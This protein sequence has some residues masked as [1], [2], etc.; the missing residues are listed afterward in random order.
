[1]VGA[2]EDRCPAAAQSNAP[3]SLDPNHKALEILRRSEVPIDLLFSDVMMPQM[4]G[5]QPAE[6]ARTLRPGL[7]VLL[8]SGHSRESLTHRTPLDEGLPLLAK[9]YKQ[10]KLAAQLRAVFDAH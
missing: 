3:A 2:R 5:V 4:S 1:V 10:A 8:S 6:E 7:R 9:P